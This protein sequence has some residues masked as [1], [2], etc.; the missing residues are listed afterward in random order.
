MKELERVRDMHQKRAFKLHKLSRNG[1]D[2]KMLQ[3][4]ATHQA[5]ANSLTRLIETGN[6]VGGQHLN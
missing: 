3:S 5:W 6:C 2:E 4:A 1:K